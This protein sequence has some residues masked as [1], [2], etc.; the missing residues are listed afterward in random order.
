MNGKLFSKA[1]DL[2][3]D[4]ILLGMMSVITVSFLYGFALVIWLLLSA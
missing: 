2:M 3:T 1:V 4:V